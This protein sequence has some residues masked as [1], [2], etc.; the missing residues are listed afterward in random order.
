MLRE[1]TVSSLTPKVSIICG[2]MCSL[3][4]LFRHLVMNSLFHPFFI[5]LCLDNIWY[6]CWIS[7]GSLKK[8]GKKGFCFENHV[9]ILHNRVSSPQI[10]LCFNHSRLHWHTICHFCLYFTLIAATRLCIFTL[11]DCFVLPKPTLSTVSGRIMCGH[12]RLR[13]LRC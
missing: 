12:W 5:C 3:F 10:H 6:F 9:N 8:K 7:I 1:N 13:L 11:Q 4:Y 2:Q